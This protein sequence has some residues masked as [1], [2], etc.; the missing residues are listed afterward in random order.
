[1]RKISMLSAG[2]GMIAAL[3]LVMGV[4]GCAKNQN[5]LNGPSLYQQL[6]GQSGITTVVHA[7]LIKVGKDQR[8]NAAFAHTNLA[9]LQTQ[10]VAYI[11]EKSGGPQVYTGPDMYQTHKG[12]HI[13][14]AQWN[15]F[16]QDFGMTLKQEKE[17]QLAQAELLGLLMPMK[18]EIVGH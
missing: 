12:M 1:M 6:G 5:Q 14:D 8:I 18:S 9:N 17:P 4:G 11:G 13:T 16:M 7:F 2:L 3:V 10:L 15:A